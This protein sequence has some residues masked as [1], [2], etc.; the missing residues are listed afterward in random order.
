MPSSRAGDA[1]R[2]AGRGSKLLPYDRPARLLVRLVVLVLPQRA[3]GVATIAGD[4]DRVT[5]AVAIAAI[6]LATSHLNEFACP[7]ARRQLRWI[8]AHEAQ[9]TSFCGSS[10]RSDAF[11][12]RLQLSLSWVVNRWMLATRQI[13]VA[14]RTAG[15][16][17]E[18]NR[19]EAAVPRQALLSGRTHA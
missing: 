12:M 5:P 19:P 17:N 9:S 10:G 18:Q 13:P 8:A 6:R 11:V 2:V 7:G 3:A 14:A 1:P 16:P 15:P 4:G